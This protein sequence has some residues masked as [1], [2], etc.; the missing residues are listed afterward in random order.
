MKKFLLPLAA[1]VLFASPAALA[2]DDL[3][4]KAMSGG[5]EAI[6]K[7][8]TIMLPDGT[9]LRAGSDYWTCFPYIGENVNSGPICADPIWSKAMKSDIVDGLYAV[10]GTGVSYMLGGDY[11]HIMVIIPGVGGYEG[12]NTA[13]G[14]G[15][16][17]VMSAPAPHFMI[18]L[19]MQ[20]IEEEMAP[21]ADEA[22]E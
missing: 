14:D 19:E 5:P 18:P 6:A 9:V 3:I 1:G 12:F 4:A 17:W 11:P 16:T 13:P 15:K 20:A 22:E 7:V 2:D 10:D 8:A 21:K